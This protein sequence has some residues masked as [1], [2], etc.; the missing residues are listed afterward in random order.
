MVVMSIYFFIFVA[1]SAPSC[2]WSFRA[3][4]RF[5]VLREGEERR[6]LCPFRMWVLVMMIG[7]S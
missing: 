7:V 1:L 3:V 4:R 2:L 5:S 6:G